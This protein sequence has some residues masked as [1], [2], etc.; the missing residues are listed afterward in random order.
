MTSA[1]FKVCVFGDGGVG[2]TSLVQR[3]LTGTFADS[4]RITIGADFYIKKVE[5]DE[6]EVTLQLWDF[7]GED[8]FRFLLPT[9][10]AGAS[11]GIFM[12]DITR[13][14]SI[15]NMK[16]WLEVFRTRSDGSLNDIPL[17]MVG[18]KLDLED[19]RVVSIDEA[20]SIAENNDFYEFMECSSKTGENV[21][22]IFNSISKKMLEDAFYL[23]K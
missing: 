12:Y 20:H 8:K 17:L 2:K 16:K 22:D 14:S 4:Y 5:L 7:A 11:G 23:N 13:H 18:G 3:F 6:H 10:A 9:Y 21:E 19:K 15:N 1:K